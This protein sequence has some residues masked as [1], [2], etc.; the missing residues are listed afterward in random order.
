MAHIKDNF[1]LQQSPLGKLRFIVQH[2]MASSHVYCRLRILGVPKDR[3]GSITRVYESL[4]HR[5][6]YRG[7]NVR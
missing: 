6:L 7:R 3:A 2:Y 1:Y 5:I 4:I